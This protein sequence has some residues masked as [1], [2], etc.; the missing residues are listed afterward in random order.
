[1]TGPM[2][3]R[4]LLETRPPGPWAD[5]N[6]GVATD[7]KPC[8]RAASKEASYCWATGWVGGTTGWGSVGSCGEDAA[9]MGGSR[10]EEPGATGAGGCAASMDNNGAPELDRG[11]P[12]AAGAGA[13]GTTG[14]GGAAGARVLTGGRTGVAAGVLERSRM[15][16]GVGWRMGAPRSKNAGG[17]WGGGE[18]RAG[19]GAGGAGAGASGG[20]VARTAGMAGVQASGG[21]PHTKAVMHQQLDATGPGVGKQ[22]A[23]MGLRLAYSVDHHAEQ[24]VGAGTHVLRL[25]AQPQRVDTDHARATISASAC[26]NAAADGALPRGQFS[27]ICTAPRSRSRRIS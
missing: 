2:V 18:S 26:S 10:G 25:R 8:S 15:G 16:A 17:A 14:A 6:A 20:G 23:V 13:L 24:T 4:L 27:L 1:M 5:P 22:V 9:G 21:A 11:A 19:S 7:G 12:N 3:G